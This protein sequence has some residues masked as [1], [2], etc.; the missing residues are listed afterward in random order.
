M[1][2]RTSKNRTSKIFLIPKPSSRIGVPKTGENKNLEKVVEMFSKITQT[3]IELQNSFRTLIY[4]RNELKFFNECSRTFSILEIKRELVESR[5]QL[6]E[7]Q[8]ELAITRQEVAAFKNDK[9]DWV[10]KQK[11]LNNECEKYKQELVEARSICEKWSSYCATQNSHNNELKTNIEKLESDK[12][13]LNSSLQDSEKTISELRAAMKKL[14]SDRKFLITRAR[15]IKES[16]EYYKNVLLDFQ[17][18]SP[19][20]VDQ[21]INFE[22]RTPPRDLKNKML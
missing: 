16:K 13:V 4:A 15:E 11:A 14:A 6:C 2:N 20:W 21:M 17:S 10:R 5:K 3:V 1:V 12:K 19:Y 7:T 18:N 22:I 9:E 8:R